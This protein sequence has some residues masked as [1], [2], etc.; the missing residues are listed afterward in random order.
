MVRR[1]FFRFLT[2]GIMANWYIVRGGNEQGPLTSDQLK[3]AAA[4]GQIAPETPVRR[5]DQRTPVPASKIKGM[6]LAPPIKL[7]QQA[8]PP[9]VPALS[10]SKPNWPIAVAS[11]LIG[12]LLLCGGGLRVV[13]IQRAKVAARTSTN[14]KTSTETTKR[15]I[16]I[17]K[18]SSPNVMPTEDE[19]IQS[20]AMSAA[21]QA[22]KEDRLF[23]KMTYGDFNGLMRRIAAVKFTND[24]RSR[25]LCNIAPANIEQKRLDDGRPVVFVRYGTDSTQTYFMYFMP[26]NMN[27]MVFMRGRI[28]NKELDPLAGIVDAKN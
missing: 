10:P 23:G 22:I 20:L 9:V 7:A 17:A 2:G 28:G 24:E 16:P 11:L 12:I 25:H 19:M 26:K 14:T 8:P 27:K 4:S 1:S 6:P 18:V 15:T 13:Q 5:E 3:Q 21:T